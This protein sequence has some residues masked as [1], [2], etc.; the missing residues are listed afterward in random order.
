MRSVLVTEK[1]AAEIKPAKTAVNE[2]SMPEK[3]A[4]NNVKLVVVSDGEVDKVKDISM[5]KNDSD[6]KRSNKEPGKSVKSKM[7]RTAIKIQK[8]EEKT[9]LGR[10]AKLTVVTD[11]EAAQVNDISNKK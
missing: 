7:R 11:E 10:T 6:I 4:N 8:L 9:S 5:L 3:E 2:L 1:N